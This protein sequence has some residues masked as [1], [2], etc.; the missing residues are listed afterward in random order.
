M[1]RAVPTARAGGNS[2]CPQWEQ[3]NSDYFMDLIALF[4]LFPLF[5]RFR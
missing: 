3:K 4:S 1:L 2:I 5:P